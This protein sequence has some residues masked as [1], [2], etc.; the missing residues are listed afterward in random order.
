MELPLLK[1]L[2]RKCESG[3]NKFYSHKI[4]FI[5]LTVDNLDWEND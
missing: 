3:L 4:E 1:A 5:N 2:Q